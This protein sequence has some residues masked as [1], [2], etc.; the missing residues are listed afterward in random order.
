MIHVNIV[1]RRTRNGGFIEAG[2]SGV[3]L[4][5]SV[6]LLRIYSSISHDPRGIAVVRTVNVSPTTSVVGSKAPDGAV[7]VYVGRVAIS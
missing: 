4:G 5:K 2:L 6:M 1:R 3:P 7:R